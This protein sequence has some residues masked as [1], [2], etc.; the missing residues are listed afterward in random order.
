MESE[1][2]E[3]VSLDRKL[4]ERVPATAAL[5]PSEPLPS[6][7]VGAAGRA[8]AAI[9]LSTELGKRLIDIVL[10]L[11]LLA[12]LSPVFLAL[13]GV[14]RTSG[15]QILFR[16][17]RVGRYGKLFWCLKFRTM[18]PDAERVLE[19]LLRNHPELAAEWERAQKLKC[20]PR[21]TRVGNF[22]RRTSLD[23]LPQL[24]NVLRGDMSLVGPRPIMPDQL[25]MYGRAAKWYLAMRPGITGLWQ[26]TARGDSDF[27]R[28]IAL[29]CH[30]VRTHR[31]WRDGWILLKT[32]WVVLSGR[33]AV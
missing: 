25:A 32:P 4:L 7:G 24:W 27:N 29:D 16:Q 6:N 13:A 14:V 2:T 5:H 31:L 11:A 33:G 28:R 1:F 21:I 3:M 9:P 10:S 23:E 15:R 19:E 30:Y 20:D 8:A 26:V 22:L 18:T 17:L 12:L